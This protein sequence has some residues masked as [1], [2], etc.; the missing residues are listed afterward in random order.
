[1]TKLETIVLTFVT[2]RRV[3]LFCDLFTVRI[4]YQRYA[5]GYMN[6]VSP[7][8]ITLQIKVFKKYPESLLVKHVL[9]F[10]GYTPVS[11][12]ESFAA[13][14]FKWMWAMMTSQQLKCQHFRTIRATWIHQAIAHA[15]MILTPLCVVFLAMYYIRERG[16]LKKV[17]AKGVEEA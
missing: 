17:F 7:Q 16:V 1:M 11:Y 10:V 12:E 3:I 9:L 15:S 2:Y 13:T 8:F 4:S 14:H 5:C 6:M